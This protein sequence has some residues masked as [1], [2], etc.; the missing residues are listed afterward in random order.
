MYMFY[1][2]PHYG[3]SP[4]EECVFSQQFLSTLKTASRLG[5]VHLCWNNHQTFKP[6]NPCVMYPE[7]A[8]R[9]TFRYHEYVWGQFRSSSTEALH[10]TRLFSEGLALVVAFWN[11]L[12]EICCRAKVMKSLMS[13]FNWGWQS[14][15]PIIAAGE[16]LRHCRPFHD[17]TMDCERWLWRKMAGRNSEK[18]CWDP[19]VN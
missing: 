3:N 15:P 9:S 11:I 19:P 17:V 14:P 16:I 1:S 5:W 18:H 6:E 7:Q 10:G 12:G 2:C 8:E 13:I 4:F